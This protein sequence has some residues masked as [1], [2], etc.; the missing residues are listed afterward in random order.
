MEKKKNL[1]F[2]ILI[3]VFTLLIAAAGIYY[4][5]LLFFYPFNF[6]ITFIVGADFIITSIIGCLAIFLRLK[7]KD[8]KY[9][10]WVSLY[11]L[12]LFFNLKINFF[13]FSYLF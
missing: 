10:R 3:P 4:V 2:K 6:P 11:A 13:F 1:W 7:K 12:K 9:F 8:E 5:Y